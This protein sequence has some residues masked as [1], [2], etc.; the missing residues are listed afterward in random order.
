MTS[1][2]PYHARIA[3]TRVKAWV[4]NLTSIVIRS[5]ISVSAG[6]GCPGFG[7]DAFGSGEGGL[8]A[9][10]PDHSQRHQRSNPHQAVPVQRPA[11][12]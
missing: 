4:P 11:P 5:A 1:S 10:D 7:I 9:V 8:R 6:S 12:R 2:L 3:A